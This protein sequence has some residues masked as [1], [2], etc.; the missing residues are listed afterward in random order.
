MGRDLALLDY[1]SLVSGIDPRTQ[2]PRSLV[3]F[4]EMNYFFKNKV[5][6]TYHKIYSFKVSKLLVSHCSTITT[7]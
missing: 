2:F 7:I 3:M 4:V 5:E 1:G 6:F